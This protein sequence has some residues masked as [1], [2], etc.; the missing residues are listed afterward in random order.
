MGFLFGL[1][2]SGYRWIRR[3]STLYSLLNCETRRC[4]LLVRLMC[5]IEKEERGGEVSVSFLRLWGRGVKE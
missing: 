3:Y 4:R 1:L 2:S 5:G